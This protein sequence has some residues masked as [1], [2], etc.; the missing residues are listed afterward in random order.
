[1]FKAV[2][3]D[4]YG[5]LF[6]VHSVT[7]LADRLFP[8]QGTALSQLWRDK[9]IEYTRLVTL[10]DPSSEGS[11]HYQPFEAL[12]RA[13]LRYAC[14]RL[15]LDLA[16]EREAALMAE[17]ACL[18]PFPDAAP[19]L[20]A[21]RQRGL[22]TAILSNGNPAMLDA[23]VGAAGLASAFNAV[24]SV[25]AARQFKTAPAAYEQ[26][27]S[28]LDVDRN[29]VLFVSSNGWDALGATW[30]GLRTFWVNRSRL[31]F[32]EIGPRPWAT[33]TSLADLLPLLAH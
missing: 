6:D 14:R 16:D 15:G 24:I 32:E 23:V 3:F 10:S 12:T 31:P 21:L 33:G 9:Q 4:A 28:A 27:F 30:F 5:T 17:Y 29:E 20:K 19:T 25:E 13:G 8:G 18:A 1:M 7:A 2:V 26:I 22:Q 11:R